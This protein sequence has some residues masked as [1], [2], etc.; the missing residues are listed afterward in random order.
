MKKKLIKNSLK[1]ISKNKKRF[2]S[3]LFMALLGV[4]F[5]AGLTAAS[6]DMEESLNNYLDNSEVYDINILATLGLTDEDITA[7]EA[8]E[9][10]EKAIKFAVKN[11]KK[12]LK[13][14]EE[15]VYE[16]DKLIEKI[17]KIINSENK[18]KDKI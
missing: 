2:L 4:G 15:F 17:I 12:I 9:G 13:S 18:R 3:L 11:K 14:N 8:V 7:L 5:F 16:N 6:P 10:I 1:S